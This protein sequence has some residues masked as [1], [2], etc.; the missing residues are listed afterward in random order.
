LLA[1]GHVAGRAFAQYA[2]QLRVDAQLVAAA[3]VDDLAAAGAQSAES[4]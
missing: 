1:C 2:Q 4:A 3:G